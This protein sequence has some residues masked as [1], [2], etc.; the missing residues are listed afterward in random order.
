MHK[1]WTPWI[2]MILQ[3]N[4]GLQTN[5]C[6]P[7]ILKLFYFYLNQTF[8]HVHVHSNHV[9][10]TW[11]SRSYLFS[12]QDNKWKANI[13]KQSLNKHNIMYQLSR[14]WLYMYVRLYVN[15]F[16]IYLSTHFRLR[17][18]HNMWLLNWPTLNSLFTYDDFNV[19]S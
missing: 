10:C 4:L 16:F 3:Y 6:L 9:T 11:F 7:I 14:A 12:F 18:L 15:V 8:K 19:T 1:I 5:Y 17:Y 13:M 2:E